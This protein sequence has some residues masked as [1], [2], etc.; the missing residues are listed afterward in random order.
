[1]FSILSFDDNNWFNRH[2]LLTI[3]IIVII[4]IVTSYA[5]GGDGPR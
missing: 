2:P 3:G 4:F 1:M 5:T